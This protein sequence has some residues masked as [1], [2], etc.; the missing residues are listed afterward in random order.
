MTANTLRTVLGFC[1]S[2]IARW[3][4]QRE[5]QSLDDIYNYLAIDGL[6]AT[7]GQP[8]G[9]QLELIRDQ[10]VETVINLAPNSKLENSV[11]NE[12]EILSGL[13]VTYIH[14]PVDFN[15][16]TD[17]DFERFA[18]ALADRNPSKVWVHCAANMRVSAF[19]YR[20]RTE[21]LGVD[22]AIAESD[23]QRIWDPFG[24]WKGFLKR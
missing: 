20:Y 19:T 16:P 6:Y 9:L 12:A 1:R 14:I 5:R 2:V 18:G 10:G 8:S 17:D 4:P 3:L 23:L 24:V 21:R 15:A 11:V 13:G 7:S 22:A